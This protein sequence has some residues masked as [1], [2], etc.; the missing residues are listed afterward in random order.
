MLRAWSLLRQAVP[1]EVLGEGPERSS[2]EALVA[3]NRSI[4]FRG[5]V[6]REGTLDAMKR[7]SFLVFPSEWY[8]GL[9]MTI[10]ESFACGLPVIASRLGTMGEMI[11]DGR[12]GLLFTPGDAADL[13]SKLEWAQSHPDE[14][15]RMGRAARAEYLAKYTGARNIDLLLAAYDRARAISP[16]SAPFAPMPPPAAAEHL[17]HE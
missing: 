7:A 13:A 14:M 11:S 5:R 15:A 6:P 9:P 12:T 10:V 2:L 4:C 17:A 8:E 3:A 1:L 16:K